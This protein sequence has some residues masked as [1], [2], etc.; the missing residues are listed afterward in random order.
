MRNAITSIFKAICR[1]G[2]ALADGKESATSARPV[3][4]MLLCGSELRQISGG[5]DPS[6]P[7]GGWKAA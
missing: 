3:P 6:L 1:E 7:K 4:M 5:E 2:A